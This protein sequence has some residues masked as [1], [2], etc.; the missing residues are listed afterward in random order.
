MLLVVIFCLVSSV[1][2]RVLHLL[3]SHIFPQT[4]IFWYS[5]FPFVILETH[6]CW[7]ET[8]THNLISVQC[9]TRSSSVVNFARPHVSSSCQITNRYYTFRYAS[10]Y[11]WNQLPSLFHQP[12]PVHFP[13]GSPHLA[14][15]T[16]ITFAVTIYHSFGL[17]LRQTKSLPVSHILSSIVF[18]LHLDCFHRSWTGL[19]GYWC[20]FAL[21]SSLIYFLSLV[22]LSWLYCSCKTYIDHAQLFSPCWTLVSYCIACI[23]VFILYGISCWLLF[24]LISV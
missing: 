3:Y 14:H 2:F 15:I 4:L 5:Y 24:M 10:P 7:W 13:S 9:R 20:L 12:Y 19:S 1:Y 21:L 22:I 23:Y 8:K 17:S 11:L 6:D 18:W 16:V